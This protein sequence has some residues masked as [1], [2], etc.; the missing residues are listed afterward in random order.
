M[1]AFAQAIAKSFPDHVRLSIHP[2][3]G[4]R[5]ISI[6]VL[7]QTHSP[8]TPWHSAPYFTADGHMRFEHRE[9]FD[10]DD[11]AEL[12]WRN[13]QPWY[14]REKN[15]LLSWPEDVTVE[16]N[17]PCGITIQ[18]VDDA[19]PSIKVV[20]MQKLR[21]LAQENSPVILRGFADTLDRDVFVEKATEMGTPVGWKFGLILEVKD[22]GADGKGLNNVL[23]AEWMPYHYDGLFKIK[24]EVDSEGNETVTSLPPKYVSS[25]L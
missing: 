12:V 10:G 1:K 23:S 14:Y 21:L 3:N 7:P 17:Y 6:S 9:S 11:K 20:D 22:H 15:P 2:S 16:F 25:S 8:V 19:R 24:K 5:K 18:R 4:S 13:G